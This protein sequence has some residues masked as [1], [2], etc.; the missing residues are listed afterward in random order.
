MGGINE[1]NEILNDVYSLN[2]NFPNGI[3]ERWKEVNISTE[4]METPYLFGHASS[5]AVQ[6]A[7]AK[8]SKFSLYKYPDDERIYKLG[9]LIDKIKIKGLYIFSGKSRVI[10]A[11]VLSNELYVLVLGRKPCFW[12]KL[13]DAKGIKPTP[14]YFHS[15][16]YY[17]RGN[18][19]IIY[20]GRNDLNNDSFALNDTFIFDLEFLE[21]HRVI[22]YSNIEG[23]KVMP[24][25]AHKSVVH[26]N[27]LIIFGGM[28]NQSYIGSYLFIIK[29]E[30][31]ILLKK[32]D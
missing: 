2:L 27:K 21:W 6:N 20:G 30:I 7:V 5:L 31:L 12:R 8:C 23:F 3:K 11:S 22:L 4:N 13:E 10:G 28:N 14:R 19:L 15:M 9:V 16:S 29:L 25:Y 17:E 32:I 1:N 24:R 26:N 18:F